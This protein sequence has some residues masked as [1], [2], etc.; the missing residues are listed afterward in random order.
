MSIAE[1]EKMSVND[2]LQAME[3]LWDSL[4]RDEPTL[5]SPAWHADTLRKRKRQMDSPQ[6]KFMT[7]EEL[8]QRYH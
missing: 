1:I 4:C 8:R 5:D 6:A 7:V 3:Q 2:R